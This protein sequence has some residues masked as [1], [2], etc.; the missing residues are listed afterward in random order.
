MRSVRVLWNVLTNYMRTGLAAIIGIALT[1]IMVHGLG[2]RDYGL[3]TT[4]F[5]LTGYFG[6]LDQGI[7]PSLV[8]YVSRDHALGDND[9]LSATISS[10]IAM[11]SVVGVIT[12]LVA[13]VVAV[14]AHLW[15]RL[16]PAMQG[17]AP[18]LVM[19]VGATLALGFP[20]GVF[21]AVLSGLQRYDIANG[22]GM[23]IGVL[24]LVAFV[25]IVRLH[26]GLLALGWASL[27]LNVLGHAWSMLAARR[28]LPAVALGPRRMSRVQSVRIA[29]YGGWAMVGAIA[30]N[31]SFQTDAAVITLFRGVALVTPFS[32]AAGLL[33]SVRSLVGSA[34]GVLSPTASEMDTLGES[35]KL[36]R[37]F[38]TGARYSVLLVWPVLFGLIVFGRN[39]LVTWVGAR[40]APY[41]TV[42]TV[43]SVATMV[44]LPQAT[45]SAILFGV[46]KHRGVVLLSLLSAALNL[47]LSMWWAHWPGPLR[48]W[49]GAAVDPGVMGVAMGTA[50]PQFLVSG[51]ATAWYSCVALGEPPWRYAWE[52]MILPGLVSLAF[53]A[54]ALGAQALWHPVGWVPLFGTC[55]GCWLVFMVAAWT[56]GVSAADRV[57]WGTALA[58]LV[59][60]PRAAGG[61]GG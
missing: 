5:S 1:P 58:G 15:L 60:R 14:N 35:E 23:V 34:A 25:T 52:G 26:G 53:V 27:G 29:Q 57:R 32:I 3:W 8:R 61:T 21:G 37:L 7:R 50:V 47:G 24:R 45:A 11:Y 54:P 33:E 55:V 2:D 31:I 20:L 28:L 12:M 48:T 46:S 43:L 36:R 39:L 42:L 40:Y 22:I 13:W 49:F 19:L 9:G 51:L 41:S 18:A 17:V 10:A 44:S 4:V 56:L 16:D 30:S 6:L 38:V 59:R